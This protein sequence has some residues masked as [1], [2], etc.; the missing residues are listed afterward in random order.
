MASLGVRR[1]DRDTLL[2]GLLAAG[3]SGWREDPRE[4]MMVVSLYFD[5]AQ[6]L[7][8]RPSSL[9]DDA[10]LLL[11]VGMGSELRAFL[12]RSPADRSVEA[13][14]HRPD[15]DRTLRPNYFAPE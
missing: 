13:I 1:K 8:V 2:L 11:P 15:W 7:G 9:F 6:K 14:G 10:A 4:G 3:L 5:A 12:N